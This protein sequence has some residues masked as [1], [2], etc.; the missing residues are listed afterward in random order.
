M[1]KFTLIIISVFV[2]LLFLCNINSLFA[3]KTI[4]V[5]IVDCYSGPPSTYT[6]DVRDAFKLA[7]DKINANGGV[8]GRKIV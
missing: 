8:L 7:V 2:V 6:N 1:K 4:K 3:A 5:G